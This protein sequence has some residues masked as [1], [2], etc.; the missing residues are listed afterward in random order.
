MILDPPRPIQAERWRN[1]MSPQVPH[2]PDQHPEGSPPVP[3][4]PS[5]H[6]GATPLEGGQYQEQYFAEVPMRQ[7]IPKANFCSVMNP[8]KSMSYPDTQLAIKIG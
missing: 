4:T 1:A 6:A 5:D 3:E 8:T 7:L 2:H